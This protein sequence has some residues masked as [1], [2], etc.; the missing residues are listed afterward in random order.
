MMGYDCIVQVFSD[1]LA[2][3]TPKACSRSLARPLLTSP[4][5]ASWGMQCSAGAATSHRIVAHP[6]QAPTSPVRCTTKKALA[7]CCASR[8]AVQTGDGVARP[9]SWSK[10][11]FPHLMLTSVAPR[12][13]PLH[14]A[15]P[16]RRGLNKGSAH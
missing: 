9:Y 5:V 13:P 2:I 1:I 4:S 12:S 6:S 3:P 15:R 10:F 8:R 16:R 14:S 11:S 7:I